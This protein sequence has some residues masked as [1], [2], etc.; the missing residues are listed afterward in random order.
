MAQLS[1]LSLAEPLLPGGSTTEKLTVSS[2]E[3]ELEHYKDLFSKLRFS[4]VEQ[5]TKENFLKAVVANP[6]ELV[7]AQ[8][9]DELQEQLAL[10]KAALKAKKEH[11]NE[12]VKELEA[13]GRRLAQCM[14]C[15]SPLSQDRK[16]M[17]MF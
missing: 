1:I 12:K 6:P 10:A 17:Q 13:L 4:Y 15:A 8:E 14:F 9:N 11:T 5:V 3:Q 2:L 16:L 7:D